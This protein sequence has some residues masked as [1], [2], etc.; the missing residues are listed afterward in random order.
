MTRYIL[1]ELIYDNPLASPSDVQ[2]FR[3]EGD[4]QISFPNGRL[5]MENLRDPAEGQKANF[6]YWCPQGFPDHIAI[7]WDF[8]PLREPGLCI[9][10]FAA[11]GRQGQDIFHPSLACRTGE[12]QQYHHGDINALHISY[13]R[14]KQPEERAFHTCNLRKSYG[15][16]LVCQGAD[17]IPSV[18]DARPPYHIHLAKCGP[19]V[20]FCIN[21]LPIFHW[22]D[23]GATYGPLL[24]GGKIGFRQMAPLIGE[25]ANLRVHTVERQTSA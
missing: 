23:D 18:E 10:F 14:R 9:L 19:E 15:F 6:V 24:D 11:K 7:S 16:H 5:R 22:V 13:F 2:G 17:P 12:Y 25:Y 21:D 8:W 4:A 20:A 3:L 1:R